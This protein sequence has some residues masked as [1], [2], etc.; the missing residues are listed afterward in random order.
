MRAVYKFISKKTAKVV[1]ENPKKNNYKLHSEVG[2][3]LIISPCFFF[4]AYR[5]F[6]QQAVLQRLR[7]CVAA[8]RRCGARWVWVRAQ[9]FHVTSEDKIVLSSKLTWQWKIHISNR[10]YIFNRSIFQPAMLV[11]QRL[12]F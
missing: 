8:S 3:I 10:E 5:F 4:S 9:V 1:A 7:T 12:N 11:Y 6:E 2:L